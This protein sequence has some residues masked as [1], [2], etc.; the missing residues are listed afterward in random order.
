MT[1]QTPA[2]VTA[3]IDTVNAHDERGFL[4]SFADSGFVDDWGR[5]FTGRAE[6]KAWSDKEFI[7]A[8]GTMTVTEASVDGDTVTVI[9]DWRSTHANGL[10]KFVFVVDGDELASM[11]IREG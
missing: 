11:T 7:G 6:I 10:S 4:D 5:V 1:I 9:A 3:F 8:N 2:T